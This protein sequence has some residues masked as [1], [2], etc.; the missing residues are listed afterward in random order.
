LKFLERACNRNFK[1][2]APERFPIT[3]NRKAL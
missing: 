1:S 2:A 3:L